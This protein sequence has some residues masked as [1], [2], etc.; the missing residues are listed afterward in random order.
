M[1]KILLALHVLAAVFAIGPLV[2]AATTAGQGIRRGDAAAT[3]ASARLLRL[4]SY[5]SV[6]V[7]ILGFGLMSSTSA[8]THKQTAKFSDTW[9]WLSVLLWAVAVALVLAVLVPG[10]GRAGSLLTAG[11]GTAA[12][13][14]TARIAASGGVVGLIF[15]GII[16]LMV[17]RPGG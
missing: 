3:A 4:Y 10:L 14:L 15:A 1:F 5:A 7:V 2:H 16:F 17:Y 6:V 13:R 11:D 8:F 9:I 12:S